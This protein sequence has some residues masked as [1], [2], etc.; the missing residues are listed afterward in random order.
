MDM[1]KQKGILLSRR[2]EL[3]GHLIEVEQALDETPTRD[4]EDFATERQGDEVLEALG[5]AELDEV[6]R[7]DAALA[8][9]RDGTYGSCLSCGNEISAAR[10]DVLPETA[11]CRNCAALNG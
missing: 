9:L 11:L 6:A 2:R 10:M 7:I 4:Y 1:E 3:V 8:R 5:Q